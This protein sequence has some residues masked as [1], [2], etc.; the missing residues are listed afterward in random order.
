MEKFIKSVRGRKYLYGICLALIGLAV[1]Y[2]LLTEETAALWGVLVS[3]ALGLGVASGNVT[4]AG[5]HPVE[6]VEE[7]EVL[8]DYEDEAAK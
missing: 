3:S 6:V 7:V 5:V 8:I 1:V 2:G 4:N